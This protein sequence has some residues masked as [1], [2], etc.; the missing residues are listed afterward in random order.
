MQATW[1]TRPNAQLGEEVNEAGEC[2][3]QPN[4][5]AFLARVAVKP[6]SCQGFN[7]KEARA[8]AQKRVSRTHA[9]NRG[10]IGT[11]LCAV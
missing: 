8:R 4:L 2:D 6:M 10:V 5:N 9:E 7:K 11:L 1:P 3:M